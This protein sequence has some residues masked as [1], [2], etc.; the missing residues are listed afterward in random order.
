MKSEIGAI[1]RL[2]NTN[3]KVSCHYFIKKNGTIL[4]MVPASY[5]S[6]HAG[7][8]NWK[9]YDKINKNSIGIEIQNPGHKNNYSNFSINISINFYFTSIKILQKDSSRNNRY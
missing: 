9:K 8:S 2:T 6:W 5:I 4:N 1:N 3:S 7:I